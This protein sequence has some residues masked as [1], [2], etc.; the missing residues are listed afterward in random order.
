MGIEAK[1]AEEQKGGKILG[2]HFLEKGM[3]V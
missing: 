3:V 2:R 1:E